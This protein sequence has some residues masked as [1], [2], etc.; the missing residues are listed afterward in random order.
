M[1]KTTP[2]PFLRGLLDRDAAMLLR[3]RNDPE[4]R[5][6]S[7]RTEEVSQEEH[8]KWVQDRI[9]IH[10][11]SVLIADIDNVSVGVVRMDWNDSDDACDLSFTVAPEHRGKGYGFAMVAR[12]LEQIRGDVRVTA[13]VKLS[14]EASRRI[15]EKLGFQVIDSEGELLMY[16][17]D[18]PGEQTA[19]RA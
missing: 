5:R 16:A 14:N 8:A 17:K 15:F 9:L 7:I 6:N 2:Q 10:T 4:T 13:L 19:L 11:G 3:W 1:H 12:A 18:L